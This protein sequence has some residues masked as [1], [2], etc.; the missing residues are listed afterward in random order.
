M[1]YLEKAPLSTVLNIQY[2]RAGRDRQRSIKE[3]TK[4]ITKSASPARL[5]ILRGGAGEYLSPI[6]AARVE[7]ALSGKRL[8]EAQGCFRGIPEDEPGDD[9]PGDSSCCPICGDAGSW[10]TIDCSLDDFL[11]VAPPDWTPVFAR[12]VPTRQRQEDQIDH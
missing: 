4:Y 11:P 7:F 1:L 6:L 8:F 5:D 12:K 2:V 9:V 3:L 10:T